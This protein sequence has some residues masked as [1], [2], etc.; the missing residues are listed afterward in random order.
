M[1]ADRRPLGCP[2]KIILGAAE[3][4]LKRDSLFQGQMCFPACNYPR[5]TS[6]SWLCS[7]NGS[8]W[9]GKRRVSPQRTGLSNNRE[10]PDPE[11]FC[12][13]TTQQLQRN[14]LDYLLF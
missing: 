10:A 2:A 4:I 9:D 1:T 8:V 12:G 13:Q 11:G 6:T 7:A 5:F 3:C 14:V